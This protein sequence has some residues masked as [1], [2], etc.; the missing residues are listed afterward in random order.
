M[1]RH[2]WAVWDVAQYCSKI[3]SLRIVC[4]VDCLFFGVF[5]T[6]DFGYQI[7]VLYQ[8]TTACWRL[9]WF[10]KEVRPLPLKLLLQQNKKI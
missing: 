5:L 4:G 3:L 6:K 2:S 8:E 10:G 1:G 7:K 9:L